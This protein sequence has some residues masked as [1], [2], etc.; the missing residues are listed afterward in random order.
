M[1]FLGRIQCQFVIAKFMVTKIMGARK[2]V[3]IL[4][5]V[6]GNNFIVENDV[7]KFV[8]MG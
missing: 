3:G 6:V 4:K 5:R 8:I 1:Y 2:I 7:G